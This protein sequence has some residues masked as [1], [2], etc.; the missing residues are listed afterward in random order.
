MKVT[1]SILA[2]SSFEGKEL[3][4]LLRTFIYI[5]LTS[6]GFE[7]LL[8]NTI[9]DGTQYDMMKACFEDDIVIFDASIEYHNGTWDS[10]YAA[11]TA[12]AMAMDNILVVSRTRL[13]FNYQAMRT[14]VP[15]LGQEKY[16]FYGNIVSTYTNQEILKWLDKELDLMSKQ[17][18][19]LDNNG[20]RLVLKPR[21]PV[22]TNFKTIIPPFEMLKSLSDDFYKLMNVKMCDAIDYMKQVRTGG[23][24]ISYRSHYYKNA[25]HGVT[26]C[27]LKEIIR[28]RHND[29]NYPV[30]LYAEGEITFEFMTEQRRWG[31][32]SFVDRKI[33]NVD[34]FWIFETGK[35]D[36]YGY[37]DSW[38]TCGEIISLMYMKACDFSLPRIYVYRYDRENDK[39]II[40]EKDK[41]YIPELS[42]SLLKEL[43]RYFANAD[44]ANESMENMRSLRRKSWKQ[45]RFAYYA[46]KQLQEKVLASDLLKDSKDENK[47]SDFKASINSHVYDE[48]FTDNHIVFCRSARKKTFPLSIE[49]FNK[50]QFIWDFIRTNSE[51]EEGKYKQ[52]IEN[53]GYFSVS[54]AEMKEVISKKQWV[55][56]VNGE[57]IKITEAPEPMFQWWPIR[58]GKRTGPNGCIIEKETNWLFNK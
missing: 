41:D 35:E 21:I 23:A 17:A 10:N 29:D 49:D 20:K 39:M 18:K 9:W 3:E 51:M 52:E 15:E 38:W 32:E 58:I 2:Y 22:S 53:C 50:P 43:A 30:T 12:N 11:A 14:N 57:V 36:G 44:G 6:L 16:D 55:C 42:K 1:V 45:Q 5:K 34:E 48:S 46:T 28:K 33:R 7:C 26:A 24:F 56:K 40:E 27:D 31:V 19:T 37:F 25:Y 8:H 47:F 13:P 54:S 4:R